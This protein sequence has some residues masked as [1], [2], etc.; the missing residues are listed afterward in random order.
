MPSNSGY[1]YKS[2]GTNNQVCPGPTFSLLRDSASTQP[3]QPSPIFPWASVWRPMNVP[4]LISSP[5]RAITT[6]RVTTDPQPR[7]PTATTTPIRTHTY[8]LYPLPSCMRTAAS[9][10]CSVDLLTLSSGTARTTTAIP[11]D[12]PITTMARVEVLT[13]LP[14]VTG[15]P[16][17]ARAAA[18]AR[19]KAIGQFLGVAALAGSTPWQ[20]EYEDVQS[21]RGESL[22]LHIQQGL[23]AS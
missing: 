17:R 18:A 5:P 10:R 4:T 21:P 2:S 1:S 12:P 9:G 7:T 8:R 22:S 6:V 14:V 23:P 15:T 20:A 3:C 19:S 11:T 13:P 16:A